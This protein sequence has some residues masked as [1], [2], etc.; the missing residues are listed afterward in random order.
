MQFNIQL[1]R[2]MFNLV[3]SLQ[4]NNFDTNLLTYNRESQAGTTVGKKLIL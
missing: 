2:E 4:Y 1:E 3:T